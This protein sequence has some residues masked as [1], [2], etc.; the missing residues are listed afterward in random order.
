MCECV[1]LILF[2]RKIMKE[3]ALGFVLCFALL[4]AFLFVFFLQKNFCSYK[5]HQHLLYYIDK[6]KCTSE[7][8]RTSIWNVWNKRNKKCV[9]LRKNN[10]IRYRR[11]VLFVKSR[12]K[13]CGSE[14]KHSA[15]IPKGVPETKWIVAQ[16]KRQ[17]NE[18]NTQKLL[19]SKFAFHFRLCF[20]IHL[21]MYVTLHT[22]S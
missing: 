6:K 11:K 10:K 19:P 7:K 13:M 12:T 16:W 14:N 3:F 5:T 20:C 9:Y 15:N 1:E 8:K 22:Y 4:F 18:R 17:A 2:I 21:K